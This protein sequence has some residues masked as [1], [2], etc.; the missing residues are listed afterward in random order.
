MTASCTV[1]RRVH[2]GNKCPI[3]KPHRAAAVLQLRVCET[4][5]CGHFGDRDGCRGCLLLPKPGRTKNYLL[6]NGGQCVAEAAG[7]NK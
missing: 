2:D 4:N 1:C 6:A 7:A 5:V 3:C